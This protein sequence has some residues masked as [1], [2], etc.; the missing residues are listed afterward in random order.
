MCF[1]ER[2]VRG[3]EGGYRCVFTCIYLLTKAGFVTTTYSWN[4]LNTV[5]IL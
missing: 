1:L 3:W 5:I 4:A 2:G